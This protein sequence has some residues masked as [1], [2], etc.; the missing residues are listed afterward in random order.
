[1]E[2]NYLKNNLHSHFSNL[3]ELHTLSLFSNHLGSSPA[4]FPTQMLKTKIMSVWSTAMESDE[5]YTSISLPV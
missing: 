5:G 2:S 3:L 1:M 4:T